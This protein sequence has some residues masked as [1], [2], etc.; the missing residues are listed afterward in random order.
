MIEKPIPHVFDTHL[1]GHIGKHCHAPLGENH[2]AARPGSL[3]TPAVFPLR[4]EIKPVSRMLHSCHLVAGSD[5]LWN[6]TLDQRGFPTVRPTD[7]RDDRYAHD[8]TGQS[9]M[10]RRD[11]RCSSPLASD[12]RPAT[13]FLSATGL[14]MA[15][16]VTCV[17]RAGPSY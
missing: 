1:I 5:Q 11:R 9:S 16:R 13:S 6:H 7:K 12:R 10:A 4:I 3:V 15:T 17:C 14:A 2:D 8:K